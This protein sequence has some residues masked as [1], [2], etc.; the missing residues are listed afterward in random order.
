M[1][2]LTYFRSESMGPIIR[3][4]GVDFTGVSRAKPH[5]WQRI[6]GTRLS[7]FDHKLL[8]GFPPEVSAGTSSHSFEILCLHALQVNLSALNLQIDDYSLANSWLP[9]LPVEIWL[10]VQ[11]SSYRSSPDPH[12][13][14]LKASSR[15]SR[16]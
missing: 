14:A 2:G 12:A 9:N 16:R 5:G 8:R 7:E 1:V 3:K 4:N 10:P 13:A 6:E 11:K 15:T